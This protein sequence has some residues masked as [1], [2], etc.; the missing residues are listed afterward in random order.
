MKALWPEGDVTPEP[1]DH[2]EPHRAD[3]ED[4]REDDHVLVVEVVGD[5]RVGD[6]QHRAG[7]DDPAP[8][9][10]VLEQTGA[11]APHSGNVLAR[12]ASSRP[13]QPLRAEEEDEE[14]QHVGHRR[15]PRGR[16]VGRRVDLGEPEQQRSH[17]RALEA[18]EPAEDDDAEHPGDPDVVRAGQERI[19]DR[20]HRP[21]GADGGDADGEGERAD[22]GDVDPDERRAL[23]V[24]RTPPGSPSRSRSWRGRARAG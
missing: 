9:P 17:H 23:G 2:V 24:R 16:D 7:G 15:R 1:H 11:A 3:R 22:P 14:D 12:Q 6:Q 8:E 4:Q 10:G 13:H 18:A 20:D 19:E 5:Q 21:R